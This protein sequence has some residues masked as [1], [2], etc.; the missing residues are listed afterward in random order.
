MAL[1]AGERLGP[2]EILETI[3]AGGMGHVY[4]ARDT[5]LNRD[6][7]IKILP[8]AFA[9]EVA[10]ERFQREARAAS[11]LN[12]PNICAIHDIG[13]DGNRPYL[14]MELLEG[15]NL[16]RRIGGQPLEYETLLHIAVQVADALDAAHAKGVTHRDIKAANIFI[17][18]RGYAKILDFG[19]AKQDAADATVNSQ[20]ITQDML[21]TPGSTIGTAAYMS[22]E[23]ARGLIVD[24]RTDLWSFGVVLYQMTTGKLP[25]NG[26]TNAVIFEAL[27]GK[28]PV[29]MRQ[30]NPQAPAGLEP[31]VAKALE[32]DRARRYQTAAELRDDLQK[33]VT[34]LVSGG[35][36]AAPAGTPPRRLQYAI[37]AVV[38]ILLLA[39]GVFWRMK[40]RAAPLTDKD[41]MVL[42]DFANTTG[43]TVFDGA[44]RQALAIQLEQS[45]FL[46][47]MDDREIRS[48]LRFMGKSPDER[49]TTQI[50][51]EICVRAGDK[52]MI[53]GAISSLGKAYV[54]TLQAA[55]CGSGETLA[56][57][58]AQAD[59][60]EHV[61]RALATAA[62]GLRAKLGE[63]LSSI[64]RL[65]YVPEQATTASLEAFQAYAQAQAQRDQGLWLAAIP[66]YKRAVELDPNF[67]MAYARIAA[68]YSNAGERDRGRAFTRQ[69]YALIDRVTERERQ[70]ITV[71]YHSYVAG[72]LDKTV[73]AQELYAHTYPRDQT[74][75]TNLGLAYLLAGEFEKS[76]ANPRRP[77]A[78]SH[79]CRRRTAISSTA[80]SRWANTTKRR[81]SLRE[82]SPAR[83]ILLR[84]TATC[85]CWPILK[86]TPRRRTGRSRGRPARPRSI[87]A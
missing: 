51:R 59:D 49:V 45:P 78:W 80:I 41:V 82:L 46:K 68:M 77:S 84:S 37:A 21:T 4:K 57:E 29:P 75:H 83:W 23:Q 19:L 10:R 67:A 71:Q 42:A 65:S 61:L 87:R 1:S 34:D 32:K 6:V 15:E 76:G 54:I 18:T 52:A 85:C 8:D 39:G 22:P 43:E 44:L 60:K 7:A 27:L 11:A 53:G 47:I 73:E 74:A 58:Q 13:E 64:Q 48:G 17:T 5:R 12:H 86:A 31:I 14:V 35:L 38:A 9:N 30:L 40:S 81:R 20:E 50:A 56:R 25:F 55:N 63:S 72:D 2:Y 36:L 28:E 79:G 66:F 33:L 69:A 3:G 70:Y 62:N 24:A 16:W 26:A